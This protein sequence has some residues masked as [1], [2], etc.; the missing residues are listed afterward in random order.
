MKNM[1]KTFKI[2]VTWEV[3]D[4]IKVE[5]ET[6]DEALQIFDKTE[7]DTEEGL[8]VGYPL[9]TEPGYVDGSFKRETDEY[10]LKII[11]E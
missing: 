2:P 9:P 7:S 8:E 10:I 4:V 5:A 6:L 11:N 1:K 3:Y